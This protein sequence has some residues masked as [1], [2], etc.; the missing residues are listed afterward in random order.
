MKA[1]INA[2]IYDYETYLEN[3][4]VLFD[5]RI[6]KTGAMVDYQLPPDVTEVIDLKG[7]LL[8]PSFVIGHAHLYGAYLRAFNPP[9]YHP[10]TFRELLE[11]VYWLLDGALDHEASYMSA[12]AM[13]LDHIRSGVTTIFDH[14]ACGHEIRGSLEELKRGWVD[15]SGLRG[16][17]CFETS[18]R[19]NID[20]CIEENISFAKAHHEENCAG[21]F[22]MH[23]SMTLSE[24][25]LRKVAEKIDDIPLHVHVAESFEDQQECINL[26]GKRIVERFID[27]GI[28]RPHSVFAHCV[29][30]DQKEAFLMAENG[31]TAALNPT[32]NIN[33]GHG[34][35]DYRYLRRFGVTTMIGNDSLGTNIANDFRNF[36]Y[37]QHT[38]AKSTFAVTFEDLKNCIND[39]Y[40]EASYFLNIPL[41]RIKEGY[42]ADMLALDYIPYTPMDE[43]S[44]WIHI[45]DAI[46][47]QS[48]PR[49]VWCAGKA[50]LV[51]YEVMLDEERICAESRACAK[52]IWESI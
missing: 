16:I 9:V 33:A 46:F 14:H 32:S 29:N 3:G 40:K 52:R 21:L 11:Q 4:Y 15:D 6:R 2:R 31:A 44:V 22:G 37:S 13:A 47:Q 48:R 34:V 28:V 35:V 30:I 27:H 12:K 18:D 51:D 49:H 23:A 19:F 50:K 45:C 10:L 20:D 42:A 7:G 26:Y 5:D 43:S 25:T 8:M 17:F 24:E 39:A 38:K 36:V 41:G 1:I